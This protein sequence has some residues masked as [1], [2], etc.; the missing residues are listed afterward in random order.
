M[1]LLRGLMVPERFIGDVRRLPAK[2]DER[3][4]RTLRLLITGRRSDI[5]FRLG[6][7]LFFGAYFRSMPASLKEGDLGTP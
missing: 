4:D 5:A 1:V 3:F 7:T 2:L 6:S